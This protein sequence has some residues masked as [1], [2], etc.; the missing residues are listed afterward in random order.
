PNDK[1]SYFPKNEIH[2]PYNLLHM[3]ALYSLKHHIY[4]D[5]TIQKGKLINEHKALTDMVDRSTIPKA[6][7]I[8]DRGYESYNNMAHIQEKGWYF[9][10][11]I[12]DQAKRSMKSGFDLPDTDEYDINL[13]LPYEWHSPIP[14]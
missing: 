10:I 1:D 11:R 8:A 9:L 5:A 14:R 3:N 7:V 12:R 6:L 13:D 4:V 2:R